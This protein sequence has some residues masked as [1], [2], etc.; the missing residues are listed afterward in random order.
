MLFYVNVNFFICVFL[1]NTICVV[2]IFAL[3]LSDIDLCTKVH[4]PEA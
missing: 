4:V 3:F 1:S 2:V